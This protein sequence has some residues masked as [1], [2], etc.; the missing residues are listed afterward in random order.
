[1]DI[2][3]ENRNDLLKRKEFEVVETAAATPNYIKA[4]EEI[5]HKFKVE[6]DRIAIKG[7]KSSFGSNKFV[8]EFYIY[9]SLDDFKKLEVRNR[10]KK[11]E[12]GK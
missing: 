8:I 5:A 7:I 3:K 12:A 2:T 1:M 11:K 6:A 4:K 10:K 9:D